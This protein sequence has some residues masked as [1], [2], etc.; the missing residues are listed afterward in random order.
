[1][2]AENFLPC[3][4]HALRTMAHIDHA[5]AC[6]FDGL[7]CGPACNATRALPPSPL[8]ERAPAVLDVFVHRHV[9]AARKRHKRALVMGTG[10]SAAAVDGQ[11]VASL[12]SRH[13]DVWATNQFF[14]HHFLVPDFMHVEMKPH[15]VGLWTGA[16]A[17]NASKRSLFARTAF[18]SQYFDTCPS[19]VDAVFCLGRRHLDVLANATSHRAA[20]VFAYN[21]PADVR[22]ID[23]RRCSEATGARAREMAM[24]TAAASAGIGSGGGGAREGRSG[25]GSGSCG[26]LR[27]YCGASMTLVLDLVVS[28]GY[29]EVWLLGIDLVRSDH[30]FTASGS[31]GGLYANE[32]AAFR[33]TLPDAEFTSRETSEHTH[34]TESR[35]FSK[36]VGGL[37]GGVK[38]A[39]GTTMTSERALTPPRAFNLSP[40]SGSLFEASGVPYRDLRDLLAELS[41]A[42]DSSSIGAS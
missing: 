19:R 37:F 9:L 22:Q 10:P 16:F 27:K 4:T 42:R 39:N 36:F 5:Q 7:R 35:G 23:Y 1:M 25:S 32:A 20:S 38:H 6:L 18:I 41:S 3:A 30:F 26:V 33:A 31:Q 14:L 8:A 11:A 28:L 21:Y 24:T 12:L 29:L 17:A 40:I 2:P 34:L 15:T 13:A